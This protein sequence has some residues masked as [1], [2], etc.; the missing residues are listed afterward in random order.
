MTEN[1]DVLLPLMEKLNYVFS[2]PD[3]LLRA[4]THSSWTYENES[5]CT[6]NERLEF[7]GDAVVD[8][9]VSHY[10][11][12]LLPEAR[13]GELSRVRAVAV[14]TKSL[15]EVARGLGLGELLR[16]SRGED[17]TGG[18]TKPSLLAN[19]FEAVIGAIY[20]DGGLQPADE[21]IRSLLGS[22]VV[23]ATQQ[24]H[25]D[26]KTR[27]QEWTQARNGRAPTYEVLRTEGPDHAKV[28]AVAVI[29]DG[30]E[31][32]RG[33]GRSKKEAQQRAAEQALD[34]I[35]SLQQ[36]PAN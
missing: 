6:H 23:E 8:L 2:D 17:Q 32:A 35:E 3:L 15:A 31:L 4:L 16:L 36:Q 7:L 18:R 22:T 34:S 19:V 25:R 24:S 11:M 28:F 13:E 30:R 26:P 21:V 1:D 29:V 27:L 9:A 10:A 12:E 20:L 33:E 14:N 5:A